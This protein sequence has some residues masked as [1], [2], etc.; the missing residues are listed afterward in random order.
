MV[1]ELACSTVELDRLLS[2]GSSTDWYSKCGTSCTSN[3]IWL[4]PHQ[5][6]ATSSKSVFS[7]KSASSSS[8]S[9]S[10]SK[11]ISS[12]SPHLSLS[13]P[14]LSL[15]HP[16]P[17]LPHHPNQLHLHSS[18]L[19]SSK[20]EISSKPDNQTHAMP[21]LSCSHGP[22][23]ARQVGLSKNTKDWL[24]CHTNQH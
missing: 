13:H 5:S 22:V 12:S 9:V 24:Q 20:S 16:H 14:D 17:G 8:K 18:T 10:S 15:S 19:S 2:A 7:S 11:T 4:H 3:G 1:F 21:H 23:C 6:P